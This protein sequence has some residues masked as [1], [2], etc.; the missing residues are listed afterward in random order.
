[1]ILEELTCSVAHAFGGAAGV[2]YPTVAIGGVV[3]DIRAQFS[4]FNWKV[5]EEIETDSKAS[6]FNRNCRNGGVALAAAL[7]E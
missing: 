4:S 5:L 2:V 7:L 6:N 1:M 3:F